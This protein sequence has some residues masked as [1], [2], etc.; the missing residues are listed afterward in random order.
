MSLV[1]E[2]LAGFLQI[3]RGIPGRVWSFAASIDPDWGGSSAAAG[4]LPACERA[5]CDVARA[6]DEDELI[7]NWTLA[8]EELELLLGRRGPTKLAF[9]LLLKFHQIHG[10]FPRGHA[11]LPDEAVE[12]VASAVKVPALDL[13]LWVTL[14]V[15]NK[16]D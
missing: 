12:Y 3:F 7:G 16:G 10:R 5:G 4:W 13:A 11:E 1:G 2:V 6:V 8:G 9:A 15:L 14:K